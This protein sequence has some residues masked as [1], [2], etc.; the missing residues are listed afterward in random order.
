VSPAAPL[1]QVNESGPKDKAIGLD[2]PAM[3]EVNDAT[4]LLGG[5]DAVS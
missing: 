1:Y 2:H 5:H 4:P 3:V